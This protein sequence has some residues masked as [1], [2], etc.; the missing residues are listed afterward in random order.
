MTMRLAKSTLAFM[1]CS[2]A[3][4]WGQQMD[5]P[6]SLARMGV[7]YVGGKQAPMGG[8][9]GAPAQTQF[10]EQAM[11]HYFIPARRTYSSAVVMVPGFGLSSYL[12]LGTPDQRAGWAE[13][14]VRHGFGV[15]VFDEPN[16]AIS[17]FSVGPFAAVKAGREPSQNMPG[18]TLWS[19]MSH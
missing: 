4:L 2:C 9:R 1:L 8:G 10:T 13:I 18:L 5:P 11:V 15:F 6:L 19:G 17:G 3:V 12:Y 14:F 7:L 16:N